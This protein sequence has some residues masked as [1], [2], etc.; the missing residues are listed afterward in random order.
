MSRSN[1]LT[2][3]TNT[4]KDLCTDPRRGYRMSYRW[5]NIWEEE[6]NPTGSQYGTCNKRIWIGII[7]V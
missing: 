7:P 3:H 4:K 1:V 2:I 6:K 5:C